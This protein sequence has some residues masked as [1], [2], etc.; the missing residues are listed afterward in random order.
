MNLNYSKLMKLKIESIKFQAAIRK[1]RTMSPNDRLPQTKP[2]SNLAKT[3]ATNSAVTP[4]AVQTSHLC[5][6]KIPFY[7]P[8]RR[9]KKSGSN[10]FNFHHRHPTVGD[11]KG[12]PRFRQ[13]SARVCKKGVGLA[14]GSI[15]KFYSKSDCRGRFSF[16]LIKFAAKRRK[17]RSTFQLRLKRDADDILR[18]SL[19]LRSFLYRLIKKKLNEFLLIIIIVIHRSPLFQSHSQS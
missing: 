19:V 16:P 11:C 8:M 13:L 1:L 15:H 17:S 14:S 9:H 7:D 10:K 5:P 12:R 18:N 6:F 2:F 4:L 3:S